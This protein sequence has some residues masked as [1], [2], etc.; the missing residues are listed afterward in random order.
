[1]FF[2]IDD[3]VVLYCPEHRAVYDNFR[4]K[5]LKAYNIREIGDLK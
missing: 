3:I 1:M 2:Y 5:L 4:T